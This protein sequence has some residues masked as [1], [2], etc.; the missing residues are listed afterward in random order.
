M[1]KRLRDYHGKVTSSL[2]AI[3]TMEKENGTSEGAKIAKE[4]AFDTFEDLH[5]QSNVLISMMNDLAIKIILRQRQ[6]EDLKDQP[7]PESL[8]ENEI[9]K[10]PFVQQNLQRL[11]MLKEGLAEAEAHSSNPQ[12]S[13]VAR[14]SQPHRS[15]G[16]ANRQIQSVACATN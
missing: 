16:R 4:I 7:V 3:H 5:R 11:E 6:K 2:D 8:I 14:S 1:D 12:T 10:S 13:T 15:T 9:A